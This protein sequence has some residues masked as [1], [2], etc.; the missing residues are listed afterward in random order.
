MKDQ[1]QQSQASRV[2]A[3]LQG[4][5]EPQPADMPYVRM[6]MALKEDANNGMDQKMDPEV[7]S[8]Q[9]AHLLQMAKNLK[10]SRN[11]NVNVARPASHVPGTKAKRPWLVY[12]GTFATVCAVALLMFVSKIGP[13]NPGSSSNKAASQLG[14]A[15][16]SLIVPE[17]H[18]ADAFSVTAENSSGML[19]AVDTTFKV[20]SKVPVDAGSLEQSLRIV[21]A[22]PN[23]VASVPFTVE[24]SGDNSYTVK[25]NQ[26]LDPGK[27]YK[28]T[29]A[30]TVQAQG[31]THAR[32]FSWAVQTQSN[33]RVL[34]SVPA[35]RTTGVPVDTA[36]EFTLSQT[37]WSDPASTFTI[38]PE[39]KG[40]FETHGRKLVFLPNKPLARGTLYT[41]TLKKGW[42][43]KD[44][45]SLES[46][47]VVRFETQTED[48]ANPAYFT[49][50]PQEAEI[51]PGKDTVVYVDASDELVGKNVSVSIYRI[52]LD[53]LRQ[54]MVKTD[55]VPA[56]ATVN[57][58]RDQE[59]S[60]VAKTTETTANVVLE[61]SENEWRKV[62][63]LPNLVPGAYAVKLEMPNVPA[64]WM[65]MQA[66]EV[67]GYAMA[68]RNQ[69]LVWVADASTRSSLGNAQVTVDGKDYTADAQGLVRLPTP[70]TW[71]QAANDENN[72][73]Q[74]VKP[75]YATIKTGTGLLLPIRM[76]P[77]WFG[78][79]GA[80]TGDLNYWSYIFPDRPLYRS[81][82][83]VKFSGLLQDRA[84]NSGAGDFVLELRGS[85]F[86][87]ASFRPKTYV[88]K[89]IKTDDKGFFD[90]ELSWRGALEPGYYD[91]VLLKDGQRVASRNIEVRDV[92]KPA[93]TLS[94]LPDKH[95]VYAGDKIS[96]KIR[97]T[98]FDG[99]PL[100]KAKLTL[101]VSGGFA[102]DNTRIDLVTDDGG[103]ATFESATAKP[104]CDLTGEYPQ[105]NSQESLSLEVRAAEGEEADIS[106][107]ATIAVWRGRMDLSME[108]QTEENGE[109]VL[110]YR[111]HGVDL[112]LA[113]G[114]DTEKVLTAGNEGMTVSAHVV[115]Q[116]WEQVQV[117]TVYDPVEKKT[118]PQYR[119]ERRENEVGYFQAKTD[120]DG[121]ATVRFPMKEGVFYKIVTSANETQEVQHAVMSYASR[122]WYDRGGDNNVTLEPA[123]PQDQ[124][125]SYDL[126]EKL[127]LAF[128]RSGKRIG[129]GEGSFLF[130]TA[131][132]GIK[133]QSV[134]QDPSFQ[135]T[136]SEQD[137]PNFTVYGIALLPQGF[138]QAQY[139]SSVDYSGEN[140]DVALETDKQAYAPGNNVEVRARVTKNG[141]PVSGA[142]VTLSVAD[143]ALL[144]IANLN[145]EERPLESINHWVSDG[146]I[147]TRSSHNTEP[148][149]MGG[150]GA[151]MG[152]GER[153]MA[154]R[155]NFKD[156]AQY[157]TLTTDGQG[158]AS[159]SFTAPDNITSWRVTATALTPSRQAGSA[160]LGVP[161]TKP[162]F[163][164]AVIPDML[165]ASDKPV[166]K[167]RAFGSALPKDGPVEYTVDI[168]GLGVNQQRVSGQADKAV[169]LAIDQLVPGDHKATIGVSAN[170]Q[171]DA[172]QKIV[173]VRQSHATHDERVQIELAPGITL[174]DVGASREISATIE[175]KDRS[176]ARGKVEALANPWSARLESQVAGQLASD[177][178]KNYFALD[179]VEG[180]G[181]VKYQR[182]SGGLA[183]L[184]YA[185][186]D[187]ELSSRV[188]AV[189]PDAFDRNELANYF[190]QVTD[191]VKSVRADQIQALSG[192]AALGEPVLDRLAA[193]MQLK[194]LTMKEK[195]ALARGLNAA[196][197]HDVARVL[198][199]S[200]LT[201]AK[202]Q[203]GRMWVEIGNDKAENL[204]VTSQVTALAVELANPNAGKLN[205]YLDTNWSDQAMTDLERAQYL[206]KL[207]PQLPQIDAQL[208]YL[209]GDK[210]VT[211]DL[212]QNP[213]T[214]VVLTAD[215]AA[216]FR[217]ASVNG[218]VTL[219]FI[220]RTAGEAK[221]TTENFTVSRQYSKD[222]KTVAGPLHE[223]EIVEIVLTPNWSADSQ[224]GCYALRD[225][226]PA[227]LVPM[228]TVSFNPFGES[229]PAYP[230][231]VRDG[232]VSFVVC[233][234][235]EVQPIKYRA[236]VVSLGAYRAEGALL[237]SLE[238]PSV[239]AFSEALNVE[240]K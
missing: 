182:Q 27:V 219:S 165:L 223:G 101:N 113:Q 211:V 94:V 9:R 203:D 11:V 214:Q 226:L 190:W 37:G 2:D 34:A 43:I 28:V 147:A 78:M 55:E 173:R 240:V 151:E 116:R 31:G 201:S 222:G 236:R 181:L 105:C 119:S 209:L 196:G 81:V 186:E 212:K 100:S 114:R 63:R 117:G 19:A 152:G 85:G 71:V 224:E 199:D 220:R 45:K 202:E 124:K 129:A 239:A 108:K 39:V 33:F 154:V 4:K 110:T 238:T 58:V 76:A 62:L 90:G 107:Y 167:L 131:A 23:D 172:I 111:V 128:T 24:S 171:T 112:S 145:A 157:V 122:G 74:D 175:S 233:K 66:T 120:S 194:D 168:P 32:E 16:L 125:N 88:S 1:E 198:L 92:A 137:V 48:R 42:G 163:V 104:R 216:N 130:I 191:D 221:N 155:T 17:A 138:V 93:Y 153:M 207:V 54:V 80:S 5:G 64:V 160:R 22:A 44:G 149:F 84:S 41:V 53:D 217:V 156:V 141:S 10:E 61:K 231:D 3:A 184:P 20:T 205:E 178:L 169:Y 135:M 133:S 183:P 65:T 99:T 228:L 193:A 12:V 144:S 234:Q 75:L 21:S 162:L 86:D 146:V 177:L 121:R 213:M 69:I 204:E 170:N 227:T 73:W 143:E 7:A 97:A 96:G 89:D 102:S 77:R 30:A 15:T 229:M 187:V 91:L 115:E 232:E 68:D 60:K 192:L 164:D 79:G 134:S 49:P 218:P 148:E 215:E 197:E 150:G 179:V 136:V 206:Q 26:A 127:D 210:S 38:V 185:T 237:Q 142:R 50:Q 59:L 36:L 158:W 174:P 230:F 18:A 225:R 82:D 200:I 70:Q 126:G 56:W 87:F 195:V 118:V 46:D 35:D 95:A 14:A 98:F 132:R 139:S 176:A 83:T 8:H 188:A 161:V 13:F 52:T 40:R 6:G 57:K 208:V 189:Y 51:V 140:L 180:S 72:V 109:A 67:A 29:I 166:V 123:T 159:G 25:P 47:A 103:Y 106:A 235:K